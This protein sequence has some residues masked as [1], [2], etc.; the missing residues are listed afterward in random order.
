MY[1]STA[2][3]SDIRLHG[4]RGLPVPGDP[5]RHQ[6]ETRRGAIQENR[7]K[8]RLRLIR[9][10]RPP[11]SFVSTASLAP[12]LRSSDELPSSIAFDIDSTDFLSCSLSRYQ[13]TPAPLQYPHSV[14]PGCITTPFSFVLFFPPDRTSP[15]PRLPVSSLHLPLF[16]SFRAE[17]VTNWI[18]IPPPFSLILCWATSLCNLINLSVLLSHYLETSITQTI[19]W[20]IV[21]LC[22]YNTSHPI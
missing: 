1:S 17:C 7:L 11:H 14:G 18:P 8:A 19:Q 6:G 20:T 15:L 3:R 12:G 10:Q 9:F 4:N 13:Y 5:V 16:F 21:L 22:L 2:S